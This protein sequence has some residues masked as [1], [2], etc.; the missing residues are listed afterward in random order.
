MVTFTS[1]QQASEAEIV[2]FEGWM[3]HD[4]PGEY[5]AMLLSPGWGIWRS[6]R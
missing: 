4:L 6:S 5:R 2:A 3:G 1:P